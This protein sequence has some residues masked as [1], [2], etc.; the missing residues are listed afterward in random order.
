MA[1][2]RVLPLLVATIALGPIPACVTV[3]STVPEA[4][5]PAVAPSQRPSD[6]ASFPKRPGEF[7][8]KNPEPT[9]PQPAEPIEHETTPVSVPVVDEN[10]SPAALP[11]IG[12]P[13]PAEPPLLAALRATLENRPDDAIKQLA[14]LDRANQD[15]VLA[16]LPLLVRV[17]R[18]DF[19]S[20]SPDEAAVIAEQFHGLA[21]RWD[22]KAALKVEK[23]AFCKKVT[24]FGRF[25]PWTEGQPYKP[26]DLAVLYV[27]LKN[28]GCEPAAGPAGEAYVCRA[29]VSLEVRDANGK[30]VEQTDPL[31]WRRRVP[32]ARFE[33]VDHTRSALRD[34]SRNY[35]ISVPSQ[36]G[37]YTVTV[38]V[39]DM[40]G[41]RSARSHAVEFRV[42]G[43]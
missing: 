24:G 33:H 5:L 9:T 41:K 15:Y 32:V 30:L 3:S 13:S 8:A 11:P 43:P 25:E 12:I 27:E 6:F 39:K 2:R 4:V 16:M 36:P 18:M 29:V 42:A 40:S 10:V 20:V 38:E 1:A 19:H 35:R 34:Y 37:V 17:S 31:D 28:V 23:V 14:T 26:N 7:V 21:G 22:A